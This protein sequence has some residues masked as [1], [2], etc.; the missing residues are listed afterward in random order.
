M[1]QPLGSCDILLSSSL[2]VAFPAANAAIAPRPV[3]NNT[4]RIVNPPSLSFGFFPPKRPSLP[5]F[6]PIPIPSANGILAQ[7]GSALA[8]KRKRL[9]FRLVNLACFQW[10]SALAMN[11]SRAEAGDYQKAMLPDWSVQQE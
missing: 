4:L 7:E 1:T 5:L 6:V 8:R 10:I 11:R 2:A 3:A 9:H